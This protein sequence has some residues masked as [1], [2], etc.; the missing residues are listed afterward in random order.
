VSRL[1]RGV[2]TA[3][4]NDNNS[5]RYTLTLTGPLLRP[6][7]QAPGGAGPY[8]PPRPRWVRSPGPAASDQSAQRGGV[9]LTQGGQEAL[10]HGGVVAAAGQHVVHLLGG[11]V[12][13]S[14]CGPVEV[15]ASLGLVQQQTLVVEA[16]EDRLHC[17]VG[18]ARDQLGM[19]LARDR[20]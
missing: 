14:L 4:S 10:Q 5:G 7:A 18:Q 17:A 1:S 3:N 13:L 11:E 16:D 19:Y 20:A 6:A 12:G 15:G 9:R 8:L 2:L